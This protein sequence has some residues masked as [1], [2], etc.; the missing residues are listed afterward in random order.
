MKILLLAVLLLSCFFAPIQFSRTTLES[1]V[2]VFD[3]YTVNSNESPVVE[4]DIL[5]Y[6]NA[7][8]Y[9]TNMNPVNEDIGAYSYS[10]IE[11]FQSI[12]YDK[13]QVEIENFYPVVL[14]SDDATIESLQYMFYGDE[15]Y[16]SY[17]KDDIY[18]VSRCNM[19]GTNKT[20]LIEMSTEESTP[21]NINNDKIYICSLD[22]LWW[23]Y[24][25]R[26]GEIVDYSE[27]IALLN[28]YNIV[29]IFPCEDK[30][31]FLAHQLT[32]RLENRYIYALYGND[33][34]V[35]KV[36]ERIIEERQVDVYDNRLYWVPYNNN[37]YSD[38]SSILFVGCDM[39]T[40]DMHE[41]ILE[42]SY[43]EGANTHKHDRKPKVHNI[44]FIIIDNTIYFIVDTTQAYFTVPIDGSTDPLRVGEPGS[45]WY[46]EFSTASYVVK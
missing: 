38:G 46:L 2:G 29:T 36:D 3:D 44:N 12:Q 19:D 18:Y 33:G 15:I 9:Q 10:Y 11:V 26:T 41:L 27:R 1:D 4:N 16:Y 28:E 20:I 30:L 5:Y 25:M 17:S 37:E 8:I 45:S 42:C 39:Q 34:T 23:Y 13:Y 14:Q 21:L 43:H 31:Y 24:D 6:K 40:G 7:V 22:G 35:V 32:D